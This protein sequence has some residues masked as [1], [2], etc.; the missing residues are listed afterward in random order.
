[1]HTDCSKRSTLACLALLAVATLFGVRPAAAGSIDVNGTVTASGLNTGT[2]MA[3]NPFLIHPFSALDGG[4]GAATNI[5]GI[6]TLAGV[7]PADLTITFG[8]LERTGT[9]F[10]GG[11]TPTPAANCSFVTNHWGNTDA[12]AP[13]FDIQLAGTGTILSG[14][15]QFWNTT[16]NTT[17]PSTS[18]GQGSGVGLIVFTGGLAPY[19]GEVLG[20]TAGT[21]LAEISTDSFNALC[22]PGS[23]PCAFT[24]DAT[25]T[26]VPE[27]TTAVFMG[28]G[29][30]SLATGRPRARR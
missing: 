17:Y 24:L 27:P 15:I 23:D 16:T 25:L 28:L 18:F 10:A 6:S 2:I 22:L 29:L 19:F 12:G 1:M 8:D 11:C 21:G 5:S 4:T 14:E 3:Y 20:L 13:Y 9:S 7:N 26:F 30:A